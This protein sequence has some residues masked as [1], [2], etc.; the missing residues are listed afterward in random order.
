MRTGVG[1][2]PSS[3]CHP[4][5]SVVGDPSP[6][7][8]YPQFVASIHPPFGHTRSLWRVSIRKEPKM[9]ARLKMSGMTDFFVISS[10]QIRTSLQE[11]FRFRA[12]S[13]L[14]LDSLSSQKFNKIKYLHF[15]FTGDPE[16]R[17]GTEFALNITSFRQLSR[18][19]L[20]PPLYL[21]TP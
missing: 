1:G 10:V 7:R 9:D 12:K 6:L 16:K 20:S 15:I 4:R 21:A 17:E 11:R 3:L 5:V 14:N 8:S 13:A 2:H 18:T 19:S